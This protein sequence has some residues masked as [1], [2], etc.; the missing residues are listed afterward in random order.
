MRMSYNFAVLITQGKDGI[1][2]AHVPLLHGC[3]TQAKTLTKL[4]QRLQEVI[5]LCI[6]VEQSKKQPIL[7]EKFIALEHME[8]KV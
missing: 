2:V 7:Q 5:A 8:L 6:E 3:H 1:F 4:H